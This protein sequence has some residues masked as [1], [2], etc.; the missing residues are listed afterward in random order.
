MV[1]EVGSNHSDGRTTPR[2]YDKTPTRLS[3]NAGMRLIMT[4]MSH[5][6]SRRSR[7]KGYRKRRSRP[8]E[9]V[10]AR[11]VRMEDV[12]LTGDLICIARRRQKEVRSELPLR[13]LDGTGGRGRSG[14]GPGQGGNVAAGIARVDVHRS[15]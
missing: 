11:S 13:H 3:S 10:L 5:A 6:C 9:P 1:E 12:P 2:R 15:F 8:S 4:R 14:G 7:N